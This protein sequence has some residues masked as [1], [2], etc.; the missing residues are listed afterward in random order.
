MPGARDVGVRVMAILV[1]TCAI[2]ADKTDIDAVV[3]VLASRISMAPAIEDRS[4]PGYQNIVY[5]LRD[6]LTGLVWVVEV[7]IS[8]IDEDSWPSY[9][10][11][12]ETNEAEASS[13]P[14]N[15]HGYHIR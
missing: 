5:I 15:S 1:D 8:R 2:E 13:Y 9:K 6:E 3:A 7:A 4:V 10:R 11:A 12:R 14:I